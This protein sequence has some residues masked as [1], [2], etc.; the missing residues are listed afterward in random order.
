MTSPSFTHPPDAAWFQALTVPAGRRSARLQIGRL[1]VECTGLPDDIADWMAASWA[2]F[3]AL[4]DGTG[5]PLRIA[6]LSC[7]V[8]YFLEPGFVN[9]RE[10]YRVTTALDGTVL[11]TMS[12]RLASWADT[13]ARHGQVALGRGDLDPAPRAFE[14]FLR[15]AFAWLAIDSGGFLLHGASIVRDGR[16]YLFYG[17][18]GAGKSTLS[19]L[20]HGGRVISDDLTVIQRDASDSALPGR[21]PAH[22]AHDGPSRL[23]AAGGPFRGT[24]TGGE[25]VVGS[26]PVAGL[27]RLRK[28]ELTFVKSDDGSCFADLIGNLPFVVDQ[29]PHAPWLIDRVHTAVKGVPLAALHFQKSTPFWEAIDSYLARRS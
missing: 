18:S 21:A 12:Y 13:A 3:M 10:N 23:V 11:R 4:P 8:E 29:I 2:P 6:V 5:D 1:A 15:S 17:P 7:P 24:W 22:A 20:A 25:P 14:N 9:A 19:A 16:A 27:F 28:S 26:Y